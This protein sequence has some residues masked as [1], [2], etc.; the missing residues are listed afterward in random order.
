MNKKGHILIFSLI[1]VLAIFL[2]IYKM[3]NLP[4]SLN[5][6][7]VSIGYNAYSILKT[8]RD[9]W[10]NFMPLSFRAFGD[11]KLPLYIYLVTPSIFVFGL[12]EVGVRLPSIL[13]G[14]GVVLLIFFIVKELTKNIYLAFGGMFISTVLPWLLIFSRIGLE[15]NLA[16]FLTTASF[17]LFLRS[18][19]KKL[20]LPISVVLLGLSAF[21]YNSSRVLI[22]PFL[23]LA[24][25]SFD[26]KFFTKKQ[27]SISLVILL[28]FICIAL[29]KGFTIDSG[30]RFRWTTILDEGAIVKIN[31]LRGLSDLPPVLN[32][33]LYNKVTYFIIKA[34]KNYFVHFDPDFLFIKGGSNLQFSIPGSSQIYPVLLPLILLGIWTMLRQRKDWQ[35]FLLGWLLIAPIP[36][37]ITRDAPHSL[38]SIFLIIPIVIITI[39]GIKWIKDFLPWKISRLLAILIILTLLINTYLFWQNY[40]GN[41]SKAY[42]WSWQY[43]MKQAVEFVRLHQDEYERI[44][45]SKIYGEPHIFLLFY[46]Q[47]NTQKYQ[48][49]DKIRYKQSD[50]FWVDRFDKY[51]FI[52]DWEIKEKISGRK[53]ILLITSPQNYPAN[54][55]ILTTV[56]FL[57]GKP[58]FEIVAVK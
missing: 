14:I 3:N 29:F 33:L 6:D 47:Y 43:G 49:I 21:T 19:K 7:E 51:E 30:A 57:D 56:N 42:S 44:V 58:A 26:F 34:S 11:Y 4:P 23:L 16:L 17:Y 8:G 15:A 12:N 13:S 2:R 53:N 10:G 48:I 39:L 50:W 45:F 24:A 27:I 5:W 28:V 36:A 25:I 46:L 41:Y 1:L 18:F 22:L 40:S 31:E 20:F 38:R 54:S 55:Q 35:K 52:N 9:E 32:Q 37:A